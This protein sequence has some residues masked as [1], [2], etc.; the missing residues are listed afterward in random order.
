[1]K[2]FERTYVPPEETAERV[3][4]I[5]ADFHRGDATMMG[6]AIF[7][8]LKAMRDD[9]ERF[10]KLFNEMREAVESYTYYRN[11][12]YQ[13]QVSEVDT[14]GKDWPKMLWLS[15][16]RIDRE[17]IHD[18]RE[19][20]EIK[21]LIVGPEHEAVELY[22][23]ESRLVDTANQYHLYVLSDP[24]VRFP[25]GYAYRSVTDNPGGRAKQRPRTK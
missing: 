18:W 6:D 2:P 13:V 23:A 19:L 22:P 16:K 9:D 4:E 25:F 17:V 21:N 10:L 7:L 15:I 12:K 11:N 3:Q 1:M 5:L 8:R 20:Q 14:M 24:K